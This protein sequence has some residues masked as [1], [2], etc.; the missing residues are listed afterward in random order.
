MYHIF[1]HHSKTCWKHVTQGDN[2]AMA[3]YAISTQ[4]LIEAL[5]TKTANDDV[6]QVWFADNSFAV[7]PLE[8]VKNGGTN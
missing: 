3:I 4:P 6:K 2:A 7:G 8:G 5:S 1:R